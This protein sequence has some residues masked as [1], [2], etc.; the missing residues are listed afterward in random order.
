MPMPV[1]QALMLPLLKICSDDEEHSV[2]E[3]SR[4]PLVRH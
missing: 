1:Y 3:A 4:M 2:S